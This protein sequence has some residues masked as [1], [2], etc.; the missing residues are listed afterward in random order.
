MFSLPLEAPS[1][2]EP[3]PLWLGVTWNASWDPSS[4]LLSC[5][6][7]LSNVNCTWLPPHLPP[8]LNLPF[9]LHPV[10]WHQHPGQK[11]N[12]ESSHSFILHILWWKFPGILSS[13]HIKCALKKKNALIPTLCIFHLLQPL[14]CLQLCSPKLYHPQSSQKCLVFKTSL[15]YMFTLKHSLDLQA[16]RMCVQV[17][18]TPSSVLPLSVCLCICSTLWTFPVWTALPSH[19]PT[20]H[21]TSPPGLIEAS[22]DSP[23]AFMVLLQWS[24]SLAAPEW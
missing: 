3:P 19:P 21:V 22:S 2:I 8:T 12:R 16:K 5:T 20:G 7:R 13:L 9:F 1:P 10:W 15:P 24:S 4:S 6:W 23:L 18:G 14:N 17:P 11:T